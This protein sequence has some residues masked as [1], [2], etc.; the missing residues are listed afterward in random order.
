MGNDPGEIYSPP[1]RGEPEPLNGRNY[2]ISAG[3]RLGDGSLK[4]KCRNNFAAI[5]TVRR[6]VQEDRAA[7]DE[8]K[9]IL[10]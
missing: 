10:V 6:L 7:T 1:A 5:E 2:R 4:Q 8:E 9:R 3:D